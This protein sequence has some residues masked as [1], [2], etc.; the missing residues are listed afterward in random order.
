MSV[1]RVSEVLHRDECGI[2]QLPLHALRPRQFP[3]NESELSSLISQSVLQKNFALNLSQ[4]CTLFQR[5]FD[6]K[7]SVHRLRKLFQEH[8]VKRRVLNV[9]VKYTPKQLE[10]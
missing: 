10:N 5:M 1:T 3:L 2:T 6:R 4:R 7:L 8:R 9:K